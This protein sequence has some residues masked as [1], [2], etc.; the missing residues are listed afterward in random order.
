MFLINTHLLVGVSGGWVHSVYT[1]LSMVSE[2]NLTVI[3]FLR[4]TRT[5]V[6]YYSDNFLK[7]REKD[8]TQNRSSRPREKENDGK[9]ELEKTYLNGYISRR[10][11]TRSRSRSERKSDSRTTSKESSSGTK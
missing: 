1:V 8:S 5:C 2:T 7:V 4:C 9:G 6:R 11:R 3:I 10:S